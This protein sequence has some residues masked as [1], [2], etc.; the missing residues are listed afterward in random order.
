M[1]KWLE[2]LSRL[3][4]G[5]KPHFSDEFFDHFDRQIWAID[6]YG[7]AGIDFHKD[8]ELVLPKGEQWDREIG[9]Y[10]ACFSKNVHLFFTYVHDFLNVLENECHDRNLDFYTD[11][12][13]V[14]PVGM[15]L[16]Q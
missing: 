12:A 14:Q 4:R 8:P 5:R 13:L 2:V 6:D 9:K 16:M 1:E 3:G 11:L 10:D 7:Y 15:S